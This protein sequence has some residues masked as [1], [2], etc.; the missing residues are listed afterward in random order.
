M[1]VAASES[2][3]SEAAHAE[4]AEG[5]AAEQEA[6]DEGMNDV[7]DT[8]KSVV[9]RVREGQPQAT[10]ASQMQPP[11]LGDINPSPGNLDAATGALA[12][13]AAVVAAAFRSIFG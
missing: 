12:L 5:T 7:V 2:A 11:M 8:I 4:V 6:V 1:D 9:G 13:G 3:L 10:T